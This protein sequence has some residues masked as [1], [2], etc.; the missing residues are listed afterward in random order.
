MSHSLNAVGFGLLAALAWGIADFSG[1]MAARRANALGVVVAAQAI[2]LPLIGLL[3]LAFPEPALSPQDWLWAGAAGVAG[4]L[5]LVAFYTALSRGQMAL[6]A[7]VAAVLG[8]TIPIAFGA[9]TEG[10]PTAPQLIGFGLALLGIWLISD[11]FSRD[12]SP[13]GLGLALVAGA[14]FGLF[15]ICIDQVSV[16]SVFQPPL[17]TRL[18]SSILLSLVAITRRQKW[19]PGRKALPIVVLAGVFDVAGNILFMAAAQHGRLDIA[20]I[21]GSQYPAVTVILAGIVLKERVVPLQA[22]GVGVIL[23]ANVLIAA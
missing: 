23:L 5:G 6:T 2:S 21:L 8:A 9:M 20:T 14:G 11:P 1:G 19:L 17:F 13:T 10:L 3:I 16:G 7:P 22:V 4:G 18:G 15:F 12:Q